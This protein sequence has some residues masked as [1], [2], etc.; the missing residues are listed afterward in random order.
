[1]E[2]C[3][4]W[5]HALMSADGPTPW[6]SRYT[7]LVFPGG[8]IV[9]M[10]LVVVVIRSVFVAGDGNG[11]VVDSI[12]VGLP[13]A[14]AVLGYAAMMMSAPRSGRVPSALRNP[15]NQFAPPFR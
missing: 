7:V 3:L 4:T 9:C 13:I 15:M 5:D 2:P 1:M 14:I 12:D 10:P 11:R 6:E 8:G